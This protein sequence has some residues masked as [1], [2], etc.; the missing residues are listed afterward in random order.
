MVPDRRRSHL[1]PYNTTERERDVA[2]AL[3]IPMYGADPRLFPLG[4]KTGC[5]R[6]F[7]EE[8]VQHPLG[9][10]DL[11]SMTDVLD[12]LTRLRAHR[13]TTVEALVKLNEGVSGRGN[14]VV[15]LRG[16]PAPGEAAEREALHRRLEAMTFEDT[17]TSFD[18]YA[19]NLGSR[20]GIVEER[21]VGAELRS[22]SVQLRVL[23]DRSVELLS[24][25]D[26]LLGGPSG[27]SY[28]GCRFP[29]DFAYAG[30]ISREALAV[31]RRLAWEGVLGRFALDF[32]VVRDQAGE[33]STYAI[34]I[35]MRKAG[36]RTPS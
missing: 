1:I 6:L 8:G 30:R 33:W 31:G 14:A 25:H 7:A 26:Q 12:A 34:E 27:Q 18:A 35:N 29:A 17:G 20:G 10:E 24:T 23:P 32:V 13:A 28:L 2:L 11:H 4:T 36:R 15:D 21:I 22:P 9:Y 3:G 5:R 16:L 19:R